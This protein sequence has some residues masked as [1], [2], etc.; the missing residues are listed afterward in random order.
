ML[1]E[2]S[3]FCYS[4]NYSL[5]RISFPIMFP[6]SIILPTI[7]NLEDDFRVFNC[8]ALAQT[9]EHVLRD[10]NG[11]DEFGRNSLHHASLYNSIT[12]VYEVCQNPKIDI[13]HIDCQGLTPLHLLLQRQTSS[14][15]IRY[16]SVKALLKCGADPNVGHSGSLTPLMLA[17]LTTDLSLVNLLCKYKADVNTRY[18]TDLPLLFPNKMTALSLAVSLELFDIVRCLRNYTP[19]PVTIFHAIQKATPEMKMIL[20]EYNKGSTFQEHV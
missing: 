8:K 1:C 5:S 2:R 14:Q 9:V 7:I 4:S 6:T 11:V 12:G 18:Q 15:Y 16:H 10:P 19:G 17:V 3:P 13:N 20:M